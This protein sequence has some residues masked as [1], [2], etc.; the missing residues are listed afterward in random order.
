MLRRNSRNFLYHPVKPAVQELQTI[1]YKP[2]NVT[3]SFV[4]YPT[5]LVVLHQ[6]YIMMVFERKSV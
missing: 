5:G 3:C 4:Q 2:F 6:E 1:K